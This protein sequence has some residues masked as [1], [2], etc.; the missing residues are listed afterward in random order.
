MTSESERQN[1]IEEALKHMDPEMIAKYGNPLDPTDPRHWQPTLRG[2]RGVS[3][4]DRVRL[5]EIDMELQQLSVSKIANLVMHHEEAE[6]RRSFKEDPQ[7]TI[8]R[9]A[10]M[11]EDM[12]TARGANGE[13]GPA[14]AGSTQGLRPT[15]LVETPQGVIRADQIPGYRDD[16][17]W[18]PSP[19][20]ADANCM[21]PVHKA[22]R[23]AAAKDNRFQ[24]P[25]DDD[26][27][28]GM[29]I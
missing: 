13:S 12:P 8:D 7:G 4:A 16:P 9:V 27:R 11:F 5:L 14:Y 28:G 15:D 25:G 22:T 1:Q 18:R 3:L 20:W 21:C 24:L 17:D 2:E 23:A 6:L 26:G 10:K 29:Y 19:D